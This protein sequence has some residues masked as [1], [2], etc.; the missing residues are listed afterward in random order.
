MVQKFLYL[1]SFQ[2][3]REEQ[4]QLIEGLKCAHVPAVLVAESVDEAKELARALALKKW[5][6]SDGWSTRSATLR[7]I[8][9]P[10]LVEGQAKGFLVSETDLDHNDFINF[11][12]PFADL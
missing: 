9:N 12:D 5:P 10:F 2:A 11:D 1:V 4:R 6:S 3:I 8:S 7:R